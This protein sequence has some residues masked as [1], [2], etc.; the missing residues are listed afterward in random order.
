MAAESG[1]TDIVATPHA[2]LRYRFQ[3]ELVKQRIAEISNGMPRIHSGCEF[4]LSFDNV[5]DAM[6]NPRPYLINEGPYLLVEVPDSPVAK[7]DGILTLFLE[8]GLVPVL[9]HPERNLQLRTPGGGLLE[10]I[11][12]GCRVQITGQSLLGRFGKSAEEC[13]WQ[14]ARQEVA[15]IV[16]SDA[17]GISDRTPRLDMAFEAVRARLGEAQAHRLFV[18]HPRAVVDGAPI[19]GELPKRRPWY[20]LGR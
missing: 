15:H 4:H 6:R 17:H 18:A 20:R 3:P 13:A 5:E 12:K 8:R 11:Q 7:L 9:A 19:H 16:A 1:T 2:N 10:L 14:M